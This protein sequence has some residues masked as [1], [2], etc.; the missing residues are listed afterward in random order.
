MKPDSLNDSKTE[1]S[2]EST[3]ESKNLPQ[4][5]KKW[6]SENAHSIIF[7]FAKIASLV[8]VANLA[9]NIFSSP[10]V[11]AFSEH[12]VVTSMENTR[13]EGTYSQEVLLVNRKLREASVELNL[14]KECTGTVLEKIGEN[15]TAILATH[16]LK[17][18]DNE[19]IVGPGDNVMVGQ[20]VDG[21]Q[22]ISTWEGFELTSYISVPDTD[23]SFI[24]FRGYA[25]TKIPFSPYG[26]NLKAFDQLVHKSLTGFGYPH[27]AEGYPYPINNLSTSWGTYDP[28]GEFIIPVEDYPL[29]PGGS[30]T[31]FI[32]SESDIIGVGSGVRY[33]FADSD[34][35]N[36]KIV[37]S[38]VTPTVI[39]AYDKFVQRIRIK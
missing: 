25:N 26:N 18:N 1:K 15:Y 12:D 38:P 13:L 35:E 19:T 33:N 24:A 11:L 39:S 23:I 22:E 28:S 21:N 17:D 31:G 7:N 9:L 10:L 36:K 34:S 4:D 27:V 14:G 5:I 29:A 2:K 20:S 32:N 16:C 3:T 30:G 6:L 8:A 37:M